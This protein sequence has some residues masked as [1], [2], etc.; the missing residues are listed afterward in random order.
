MKSPLK[1]T[2]KPGKNKDG[3]KRG[4]YAQ[5][6]SHPWFTNPHG[7]AQFKIPEGFV[8]G[9]PRKAANEA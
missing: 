5:D 6:R 9:K 7:S 4:M 1:L 3:Q 8:P 2:P